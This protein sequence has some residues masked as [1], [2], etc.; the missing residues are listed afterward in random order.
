MRLRILAA[1]SMTVAVLAAT[2]G[3]AGPASA[4]PASWVMPDVR[5]MVVKRAIKS[6]NEVTGSAEL[7]IRLMDQK[8]GQEV[9]NQTNWAV[10]QQ[11]PR[12]GQAISQKT[13]TVYLGVKRFNQQR[14]S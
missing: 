14:C 13:K 2:V 9:T 5:N 12:A 3:F 8:A 7:D 10:C 4:A 6:I 11:S 1:F